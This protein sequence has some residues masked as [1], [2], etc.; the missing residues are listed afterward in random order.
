MRALHR[1]SWAEDI[2]ESTTGSLHFGTRLNFDLLE[3]LEVALLLGSFD[4]RY[5]P[6]VVEE[7]VDGGDDDPGLDGE[8]LDTHQRDASP[9]VDDDALVE[10]PVEHFYETRGVWSD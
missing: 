4:L 3:V 2:S 8:Y 6:R 1:S 10:D 9:D 5:L 7:R